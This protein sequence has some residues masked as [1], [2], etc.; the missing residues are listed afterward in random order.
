[1]TDESNSLEHYERCSVCGEY[2]PTF[3][4]ALLEAAGE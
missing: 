1:M 4:D 3:T 2:L